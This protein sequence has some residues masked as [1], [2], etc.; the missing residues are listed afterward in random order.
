[1]RRTLQAG[2]DIGLSLGR[3]YDTMWLDNVSFAFYMNST[4]DSVEGERGAHPCNSVGPHVDTS[5][6][7]APDAT[8][9]GVARYTDRFFSHER[10][11]EEAEN[12]TLPS[13]AWLNCKEEA[14]DHPW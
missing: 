6:V 4:C 5:P 14:C 10:F 1:V 2:A 8:I 11:Y 3:R 13:F 7:Y 12:G 9:A